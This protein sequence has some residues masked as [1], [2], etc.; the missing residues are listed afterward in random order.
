MI[1]EGVD[2]NATAARAASGPMDGAGLTI[3]PMCNLFTIFDVMFKVLTG[4]KAAC[5]MGDLIQR[6]S[7]CLLKECCR[8]ISKSIQRPR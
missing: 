3:Q 2:S 4:T 7:T 8:F 5:H 1:S 6:V